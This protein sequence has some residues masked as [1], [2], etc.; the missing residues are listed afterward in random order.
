MFP[1]YSQ[2]QEDWFLNEHIFKNKKG[3]IYIEL[4]ALDGVLYSNTKFFEDSLQWTGILIEPHPEKF[5]K[6]QANRPHNFL[7]N[8]LISCH[9]E[10]LEF[11]Y[12][13]DYH[14]AVSGVENT[15]SQFHFNTFFDNIENQH[16]PQTKMWIQPMSLTEVVQQTKL[17][18]ID[19]LSL[20]VE[21]HEY[22][23]LKSWDF[24]IPID[25]ILIETL[26]EQLDREEWCREILL[27]NHYL[28]VTKYRHNE[29]Y[30]LPSFAANS[31][32]PF[33]QK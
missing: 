17:T 5:K 8:Q 2:S 7:F 13:V 19:L 16:L 25:V 14:A 11:R 26:G 23:V 22:E 4:G 9:K 30:V 1:M 18:H 15:L 21:G 3:G 27:R 6:L 20:D 10:P 31:D 12:F 33:S 28:F 32:L 29:V 24:S